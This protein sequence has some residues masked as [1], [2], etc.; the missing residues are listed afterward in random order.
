MIIMAVNSGGSSIKYALYEFQVGLHKSLCRGAVK[1]LY[2]KDSFIEQHGDHPA[3]RRA[4]PD[5]DHER[6]LALM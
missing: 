1:R 5:L 2:R 4:V 3:L 6:G